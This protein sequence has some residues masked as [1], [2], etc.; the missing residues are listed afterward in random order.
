MDSYD[1]YNKIP[2]LH[3]QKVVDIEMLDVNCTLFMHER[4]MPNGTGHGR[5]HVT[6][7]SLGSKI[8]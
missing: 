3:L 4:K 1:H 8:T 7:R 6:F 2:I 5:R